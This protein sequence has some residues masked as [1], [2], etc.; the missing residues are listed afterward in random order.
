MFCEKC[1]TKVDEGLA[2]C[3]NCG[4]RLA[5]PA[6]PAAPAAPVQP[7]AP[8][9]PAASEIPANPGVE[10]APVKPSAATK[11]ASFPQKPIV[12]PSL[13]GLTDKFNK[14]QG[15]AQ[16]YYGCTCVL[17]IVCFI[18]SLLKV[19][20]LSGYGLPMAAGS[21]FFTSVITVLFT[22]A[23]VFFLQDAF[24]KFS[25]K[26]LWFFI[27]GVCVVILLIFVFMW[28]DSGCKLSV[29]GWFFLILQVCLT[30]A[31]ILF[32]LEQLKKK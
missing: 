26:W 20:S 12:L 32:L 21:T 18:L 22:L 7:A 5:V 15:L 4:N 10:K 16:I 30:A 31:S 9:A 24:G 28:I 23:I 14:M 8:A 25:F 3:P 11:A 13:G 27:A 6:A 1:G 19:F 29:G 17:L 2:F